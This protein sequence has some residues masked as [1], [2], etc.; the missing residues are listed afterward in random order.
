MLGFEPEGGPSGAA[1]AGREH[2]DERVTRRNPLRRLRK[3]QNA[4]A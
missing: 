3:R 2:G 4:E 1:V